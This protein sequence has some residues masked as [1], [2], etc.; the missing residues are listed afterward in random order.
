MTKL[1]L[2]NYLLQIFFIRLTRCLKADSPGVS[3]NKKYKQRWA[4]KY[5]VVPF[6]GWISD[7]K[8]IGKEG[9]LFITKWRDQ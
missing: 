6:T 3:I 4:I 9:M 7:F 5:W 2:T 8:F 1:Q